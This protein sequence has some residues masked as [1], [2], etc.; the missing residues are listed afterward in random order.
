[1]PT[2][3]PSLAESTPF[4]SPSLATIARLGAS[5]NMMGPQSDTPHSLP[6]SA[7]H[8]ACASA[9]ARR[10]ESIGMGVGACAGDVRGKA[11]R[12]AAAAANGNFIDLDLRDERRTGARTIVSFY[13]AVRGWFQRRASQY[14][15]TG[16]QSWYRGLTSW[17]EPIGQS[18]N[19]TE[20]VAYAN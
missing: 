11:N 3:A 2:K 9:N 19:M 10:A 20:P 16:S 13:A 5:T 12:T 17:N 15:A 18:H 7:V 8:S 1:M 14:E 4:A 6:A